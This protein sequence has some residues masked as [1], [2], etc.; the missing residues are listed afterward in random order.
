MAGGFSRLN[1]THPPHRDNI[2]QGEVV[3]G[4][5]QPLQTAE[6]DLTSDPADPPPHPDPT[7][8][9]PPRDLISVFVVTFDPKEGT[10]SFFFYNLLLIIVLFVA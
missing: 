5:L 2:N 6:D 9:A 1:S 10:S 4:N 3:H 7:C 8:P